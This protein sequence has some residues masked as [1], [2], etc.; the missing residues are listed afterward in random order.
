MLRNAFALGCE[1]TNVKHFD[2]H[3]AIE[4][5]DQVLSIAFALKCESTTV[6][7]FDVH[8]AIESSDQVPRIAFALECEPTNVRRLMFRV[9]LNHS[10]KY[11]VR[12]PHCERLSNAKRLD[13]GKRV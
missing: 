13:A 9:R 7:R 3:R 1:S 12:H 6:R 8:G 11:S 2:V 5:S 4:S 10:I